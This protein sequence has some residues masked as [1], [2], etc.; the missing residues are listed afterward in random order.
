MCIIQQRRVIA[1]FVVIEYRVQSCLAYILLTVQVLHPLGL[2][3]K[4]DERVEQ[5]KHSYLFTKTRA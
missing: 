5:G 2:R 1:L 4:A 3:L